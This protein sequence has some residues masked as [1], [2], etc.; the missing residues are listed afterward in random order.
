MSVAVKQINRSEAT[1]EYVYQI[2]GLTASAKNSVVLG[3]VAP[4]DFIPD[5]L[6]S[7]V[8]PLGSAALATCSFDQESLLNDTS[9]ATQVLVDIYTGANTTA[10]KFKLVGGGNPAI[11]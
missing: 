10:V 4:N 7:E 8:V 9:D 3:A 1:C 5:P 11:I 2:T 6:S